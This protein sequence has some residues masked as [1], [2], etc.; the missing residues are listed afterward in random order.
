MEESKILVKLKE[1]Y[2]YKILS[3]DFLQDSGGTTYIVNGEKQK[4]FL[5]IAGK[6]FQNTIRQSVDIVRYLSRKG[7]PEKAFQFLILLKQN[8]ECRCWKLMMKDRSICLFCMNTLMG[9]NPISAHAER[10]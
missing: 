8:W 2:D 6:A 3:I 1:N 5:K 7:F 10:K 4:F 9:K